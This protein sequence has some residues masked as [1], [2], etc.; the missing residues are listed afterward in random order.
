[1]LN[2]ATCNIKQVVAVNLDSWL[3]QPIPANSK[4]S[5]QL[6]SQGFRLSNGAQTSCLHFLSIQLKHTVVFHY[7]RMGTYLLY[8]P[9]FQFSNLNSFLYYY[10]NSSLREVESLLHNCRQFANSSALLT[11]YVLS[12]GGQN[13]D[14]GPGGCYSHLNAAVSIFSKFSSKELVQFGLEHSVRH[15]L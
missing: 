14:F 15:E 2:T 11:Q 7:S 13:D 3:K 8:I 1:M 4:T 9:L 6:V 10:L 12:S 5:Q